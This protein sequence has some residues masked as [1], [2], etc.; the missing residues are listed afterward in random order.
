VLFTVLFPH[1]LVLLWTLAV[2]AFKTIIR[3]GVFTM[4]EKITSFKEFA[5]RICHVDK[6]SPLVDRVNLRIR[7]YSIF[8]V[9]LDTVVPWFL[10]RAIPYKELCY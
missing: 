1:T 3:E 2:H 10:L 9:M 7:K 6:T 4:L 8:F 5:Y